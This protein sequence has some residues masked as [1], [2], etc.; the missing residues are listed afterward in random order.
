MA[1]SIQNCVTEIKLSVPLFHQSYAGKENN[2]HPGQISKLSFSLRICP[3]QTKLPWILKNVLSQ[4][5][6]H[7]YVFGTKE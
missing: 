4:I 3:F 2:D 6:V 1:Q 7:A 5:R